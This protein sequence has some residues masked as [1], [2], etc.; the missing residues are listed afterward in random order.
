[1][2]IPIQCEHSLLFNLFANAH[3]V[4]AAFRLSRRVRIYP[5]RAFVIQPPALASVLRLA[6]E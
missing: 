3:R 5:C 1:M 6:E 2:L 4:M